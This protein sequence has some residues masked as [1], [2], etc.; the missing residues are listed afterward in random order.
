[1]VLAIKNMG[2]VFLLVLLLEFRFL[3]CEDESWHD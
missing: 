1:V 3:P 2:A